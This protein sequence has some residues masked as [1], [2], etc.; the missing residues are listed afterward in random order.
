MSETPPFDRLLDLAERYGRDLASFD[1]EWTVPVLLR[2]RDA[3]PQVVAQP[4]GF[5]T[6]AADSSAID[7]ALRQTR[8]QVGTSA[9]AK[10][11][12]TTRVPMTDD[13]IR[14]EKRDGG[15]FAERIGIG[16]APK[17]DVQILLSKVSKYHAY[18]TITPDGVVQLADA[19]STFGTF[20]EGKKLEPMTPISLG[21]GVA[22]RLATYEFR[23]H[24]PAGLR[25]AIARQY[26]IAMR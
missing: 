9:H 6:Q 21:D 23:F 24:T 16:R 13:V 7:A 5:H 10:V 1:R 15:A 18:V 14:L 12:G 22:V 4:G 11:T 3:T 20:V 8:D 19:R 2:R 25:E 26:R 17:V